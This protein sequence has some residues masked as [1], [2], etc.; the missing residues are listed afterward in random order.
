IVTDPY[1]EKTADTITLKSTAR[2]LV[3]GAY[4]TAT[5]SHGALPTA[6]KERVGLMPRSAVS[7]IAAILRYIRET[8]G[9]DPALMDDYAYQI[10]REW[11]PERTD[12]TQQFKHDA[13][14]TYFPAVDL[15]KM[16]VS[17][18]LF[19]Y[20]PNLTDMPAAF[21]TPNLTSMYCT[22]VGCKKL[23]RLP[24]LDT[25]KVYR[26]DAAFLECMSITELPPYD[27]SSCTNTGW[28][29][30]RD[31]RKLEKVPF[32]DITIC[33]RLENC[34]ENC[35]ELRFVH[36]KGFGT[37]EDP[38][39]YNT[40]HRVAKWGADSEENRRSL[41]DTLLTD[42]FDRAAAGYTPLTVQLE[43]EVLARLTDA[44]K[45]GIAAKGFTLASY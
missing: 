15:S 39:Y 28:G 19:D 4:T 37:I 12:R 3:G 11:D 40:F 42:S 8:T 36:L 17:S 38:N 2:K 26:A 32:L 1:W 31:C 23:K 10:M 22:F 29:L 24:M 33:Q 18:S 25:G 43:P 13:K 16:V 6:T 20:A 14:L 44:E 9:D 41:V 35:Y 7:D 45:A 21:H 30:C 5:V 27:F 34:F